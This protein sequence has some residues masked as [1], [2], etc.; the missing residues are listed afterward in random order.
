[1]ETKS[2]RMN[3]FRIP[4]EIFFENSVP[5]KAPVID[6]AII[7]IMI[8]SNDEMAITLK[9]GILKIRED[10]TVIRLIAI[11]KATA[12]LGPYLNSPTRTG[13]LNSAPP[14][15]IKPPSVLIG[16]PVRNA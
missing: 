7:E 12:F 9:L 11:F 13:S 15:P 3:F 16:M 8:K 1:M 4:S 10:V 5:M 14:R 6:P 2:I